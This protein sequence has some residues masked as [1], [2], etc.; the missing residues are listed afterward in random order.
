ME[1][2]IFCKIV[3]GEIPSHKVYEDDEF[4]AFLDIRPQAPG[5]T[6]VIPKKH[7]RWVWDVPNAG[8]YFEVAQKV[9]RAMQN[10]F[11][12]IDEVHSRIMGEEVPHA[13]IWIYPAP[14]K[15]HG[16]KNDLEGNAEKIREALKSSSSTL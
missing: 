9:A 1:D 8:K 3:A 5:H 6:Q 2:C 10:T 4:L 12:P 13:H 16:D 11:G 7:Y 15:A 14:S